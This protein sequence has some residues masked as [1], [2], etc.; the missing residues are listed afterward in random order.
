M[1][2]GTLTEP[3][4]YKAQVGYYTD[5]ETGLQLLTHRYY[6]P[7]RGRFLT[8]DP[9]GYAGGVNLYGYTNNNPVSLIDPLGSQGKLKLPADPSGLGPERE[10]DPTHLDPFGSRWR[11]PGGD[12]LDFNKGRPGLPGF[13]GRDHWHHNGG[14]EHYLPGDEIE[15]GDSPKLWEC[16]SW[17]IPPPTPEQATQIATATVGTAV[18][19]IIIIIFLPVGA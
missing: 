10:H 4:G 18:V 12:Y 15:V 19:I 17:N 7:S 11:G 1:L 16:P 8:R 3:F 9:V 6:D 13:R 2:S 14:D 5:T